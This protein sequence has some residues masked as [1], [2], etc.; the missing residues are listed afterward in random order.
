MK[1]FVIDEENNITV[2]AENW[3]TKINDAPDAA[4]APA[5][6]PATCSAD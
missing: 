1:T 2:F 5:R 4:E 3:E 6:S